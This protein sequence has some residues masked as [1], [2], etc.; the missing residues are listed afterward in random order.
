MCI[1]DRSEVLSK[2][3][4]GLVTQLINGLPEREPVFVNC[5]KHGGRNK[6]SPLIQAEF[7]ETLV[8]V[9]GESRPISIYRFGQD[10]GRVEMRFQA[11][12]EGFLPAALASMTSKY[13][14][15][16]AMR[17]FNDFWCRRVDDL[18]P[19]AGYPVDAR[20][21]HTQIKPAQ[22]RLA[23]SDTALWRRK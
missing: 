2:T 19:T 6:Y 11:K 13:L 3:T 9:H 7:P 21:F 5:D 22:K 16:L 20:R 15:E 1:R 10:S 23:I 18:K 8:E 12:G 14:R 17:A 4:L